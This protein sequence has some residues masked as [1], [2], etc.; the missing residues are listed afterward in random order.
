MLCHAAA[1]LV[2]HC[3]PMTHKMDARLVLLCFVVGMS[4]GGGGGSK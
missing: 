3:L 4:V 2:L 1:D